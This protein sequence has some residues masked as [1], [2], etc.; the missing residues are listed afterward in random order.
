MEKKEA[1]FIPYKI[2]RLAIGLIINVIIIFTIVVTMLALGDNELL[3]VWNNTPLYLCIT[4]IILSIIGLQ[5]GWF[6]W[7]RNTKTRI[8]ISADGIKI[9]SNNKKAWQE[10]KDGKQ[11]AINNKLKAEE[12]EGMVYW[13]IPIEQINKAYYTKHYFYKKLPIIPV[14][15]IEHEEEGQ[16]AETT[17]FGIHRFG[18]DILKEELGYTGTKYSKDGED[19]VLEVGEAIIGEVEADTEIFEEI[20]KS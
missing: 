13:E 4:A 15:V 20:S 7:V 6:I 2:S 12:Q 11:A 14:L 9:L 17:V 16:E 18:L 19:D 3:T 1:S 5:G 8:V 10:I